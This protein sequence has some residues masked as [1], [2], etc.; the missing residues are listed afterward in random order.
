M[1]WSGRPGS[2]AICPRPPFTGRAPPDR[3]GAT[4]HPASIPW[5]R[6]CS[7]P[8]MECVISCVSARAMGGVRLRWHRPRE[9]FAPPPGSSSYGRWG[10]L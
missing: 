4:E 2:G 1:N 9:A 8:I 3:A 5:R 6:D 10:F 7:Q